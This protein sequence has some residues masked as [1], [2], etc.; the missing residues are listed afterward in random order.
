MVHVLNTAGV[1]SSP[2]H[3]F[4]DHLERTRVVVVVLLLRNLLSDEV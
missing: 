1:Q 2:V 4:G 3:R